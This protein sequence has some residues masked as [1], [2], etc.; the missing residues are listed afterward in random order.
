MYHKFF[1]VLYMQ[2]VTNSNNALYS[3]MQNLLNQEKK[4][5]LS[6]QNI[7]NSANENYQRVALNSYV[8]INGFSI[9]NTYIVDDERYNKLLTTKISE[10]CT[11]D[12]Q[13]EFA[14]KIDVLLGNPTILNNDILMNN[15]L[16][17][18]NSVVNTFFNSIQ[19]LSIFPSDQNAK[20]TTINSAIEFTD[21]IRYTANNLYDIALEIE[22]EISEVALSSNKNLLSLYD[23]NQKINAPY[24]NDVQIANLIGDQNGLLRELSKFIEIDYERLSDN[25]LVIN[26]SNGRGTLLNEFVN[27][28][29]YE[30]KTLD[31]LENSDTEKTFFLKTYE[32][33]TN[34][35]IN[36]MYP[37]SQDPNQ[38]PIL[39]IDGGDIPNGYIRGLIDIQQKILDFVSKIDD[40]CFNFGKQFNQI[41]A[42]G[43]SFPGSDKIASQITISNSQKVTLNKAIEIVLLDKYNGNAAL[44]ED[45]TEIKPMS[46]VLHGQS[47]ED[48]ITEVNNFYNPTISRVQLD[49]KVRDIQ[50][51]SQNYTNNTIEMSIFFDELHAEKI[52]I[53][54]I[55]AY[56]K[57]ADGNINFDLDSVITKTTELNEMNFKIDI[58]QLAK[59]INLYISTELNIDQ[60]IITTEFPINIYNAIDNFTHFTASSVTS[61]ANIIQN[62]G[63]DLVRKVY[64]Y[65]EDENGNE[66]SSSK[67]G[68][69]V[70]KSIDERY[71]IAIKDANAASNQKSTFFNTFDSNSFFDITETAKNSSINFQISQSHIDNFHFNTARLE[72]KQGFSYSVGAGD[73]RNVIELIN[74]RNTIINFNENESSTFS[75]YLTSM[76]EDTR[77]AI[78]NIKKI[79]EIRQSDR[80][81]AEM[82]SNN[83]SGVNIDEEIA[84]IELA[85]R[86]YQASGK[87]IETYNELLDSLL[88]IV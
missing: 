32:N 87:M 31:Q 67:T 26:M 45:G 60:E 35:H 28:I 2:Q 12:I 68:N 39:S 54:K 1:N 7:A 71:T 40:F 79:H 88:A 72:T 14:K 8:N 85:K 51:I 43:L 38:I 30:E 84:N 59:N 24:T 47:L 65:V 41:Y 29:Y 70:I 34:S 49:D 4:L 53:E 21:F 74:F 56:T 78:V 42:Q 44:H 10:E 11:F 20:K 75:T 19:Q 64:T 13:T 62:Y 61:P 18:L 76:L 25:R 83:V 86:L 5:A 23:I 9:S 16:R 69:L 33:K 22:N 15:N 66:I 3:S 77:D 50:L 55:H 48:I 36:R 81:F 52:Q 73:N 58:S 6:S 17:N 27:Q 82:L 57:D 63:T 37:Q 46:L 80:N